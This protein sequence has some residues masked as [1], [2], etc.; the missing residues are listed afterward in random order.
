M[1]RGRAGYVLAGLAL[2]GG[3]GIGALISIQQMRAVAVQLQQIVVPGD[4]EIALAESGTH[5]IF[6]E[7]RAVV[8]GRYFAGDRQLS[9]LK[10]SLRPALSGGEIAIHPP[11]ARTSYT[12]ADREGASI[13]AFEVEQPGTYRLVAWYPEPANDP[14]AVLAIGYGV[15]R[16]LALA[17]LGSLASG[18]IGL[19]ACSVIAAATFLR[20]RRGTLEQGRG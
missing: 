2:A 4:H 10:L 12:L 1:M 9:G 11:A 18:L 7:Q 3:V 16:R 19:V 14:T 17:V 6:H 20:G 15:E 5:T 13:A 8:E